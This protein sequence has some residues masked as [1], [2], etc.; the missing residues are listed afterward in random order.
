MS[1]EAERNPQVTHEPEITVDAEGFRIICP[2]GWLS[3][4]APTI[5]RGPIRCMVEVLTSG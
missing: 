4:P 1:D 2:C 5:G 3:A